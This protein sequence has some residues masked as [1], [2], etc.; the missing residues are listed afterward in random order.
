MLPLQSERDLVQGASVTERR[1]HLGSSWKPNL[2]VESCWKWDPRRSLPSAERG[3]ALSGFV[4]LLLVD[5]SPRL[6]EEL[7][8]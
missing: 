8:R 6:P 7:R 3:S 5:E 4:A 2:L 1:V